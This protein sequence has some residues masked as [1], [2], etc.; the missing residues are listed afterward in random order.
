MLPSASPTAS[1][2]LHH[3]LIHELGVLV[4]LKPTFW[5]ERSCIFAKDR[6]IVMNYGR[7]KTDSPASRNVSAAKHDALRWCIALRGDR[8][9]T[10]DSE[11]L[12]DHGHEI[13]KLDRLVLLYGRS[14]SPFGEC[15]VDFGSGFFKCLGVLHHEVEDGSKGD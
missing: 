15:S 9:R 8:K 14:K 6:F 4:L 7:V 3:A 13:R 11:R 1:T 10:I 2:K 12:F 5:S